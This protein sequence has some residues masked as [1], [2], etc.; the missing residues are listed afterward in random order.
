MGWLGRHLKGSCA[1]LGS[2]VMKSTC[3]VDTITVSGIVG[4]GNKRHQEC[5]CWW[6]RAGVRSY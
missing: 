4:N 6:V 2:Y 1:S 5:S 3:A